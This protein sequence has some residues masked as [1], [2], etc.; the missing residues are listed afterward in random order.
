MCLNLQKNS[1]EQS[2]NRRNNELIYNTFYEVDIRVMGLNM[3]KKVL[4]EVMNI[5]FLK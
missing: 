4:N 1:Q 2:E 5:S 3:K